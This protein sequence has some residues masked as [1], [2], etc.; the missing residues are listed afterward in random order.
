MQDRF[1]IKH[2]CVICKYWHI[3]ADMH[4]CGDC[5]HNPQH[6]KQGGG[7]EQAP[8]KLNERIPRNLATK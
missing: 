8:A 7:H 1:E 3:D 4:P 2:P 6:K 5:K